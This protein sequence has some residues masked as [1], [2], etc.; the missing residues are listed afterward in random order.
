MKV[1]PPRDSP[2]QDNIPDNVISAIQPYMANDEF[3]PASIAKVSKACT[4]ICQWVRAMH[5]YHFVA[6]GVEPKRVRVNRFKVQGGQENVL[7]A[8]FTTTHHPCSEH[9][10]RPR[11]TWRPRRRSWTRPKSSSRRWRAASPLC[12]PSTRTAWPIRK[13]WTTSSSCVERD[14]SER[15]RSGGREK[16]LRI[17]AL[18]CFAVV[19][20][21]SQKA[22][23]K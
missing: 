21:N 11:K 16:S 12:R 10:G 18:Q 9:S 8:S 5:D 22:R 1:N 7:N 2:L 17:V 4:S 20:S 6:K 3:Q 14:S 23:A 15:T 13:S 19:K